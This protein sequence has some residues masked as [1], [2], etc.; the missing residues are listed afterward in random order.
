MAVQR[1]EIGQHGA[2]GAGGDHAAF[3][4][5]HETGQVKNGKITIPGQLFEQALHGPLFGIPQT[6]RQA[7]KTRLAATEFFRIQDLHA[8]TVDVI[9]QSDAGGVHGGQQGL[10]DEMGLP[11]A[12]GTLRGQGPQQCLD[13]GGGV[14]QLRL[15]Q[16]HGAHLGRQMVEGGR[17][18]PFLFHQQ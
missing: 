6:G 2:I 4:G 9:H 11:A 14:P 15:A 18:E 17:I 1:Q 13:A 5:G 12:R 8:D 3:V 10:Q 16:E 7:Q